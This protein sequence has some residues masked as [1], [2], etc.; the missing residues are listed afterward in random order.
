MRAAAFRADVANENNV[1]RLFDET[2]AAFGR[3]DVLVAA[4]G[5]WQPKPLE[6]VTAEDVAGS[7][8]STRS[9][10]SSVASEPG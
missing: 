2:L 3:L 9:A 8:P 7:S 1:A 5:V 6:E 10:R 4:A